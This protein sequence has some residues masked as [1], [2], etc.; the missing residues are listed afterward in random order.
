MEHG[1]TQRGRGDSRRS[2][3]ADAIDPNAEFERSRTPS[4]EGSATAAPPA[5]SQPPSTA[6][7]SPT[8]RRG[9][10]QARLARTLLP[11]G[12]TPDASPAIVPPDMLKVAGT[13]SAAETSTPKQLAL[14]PSVEGDTVQKP[15]LVS[16]SKST[17]SSSG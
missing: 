17:D 8:E 16:T 12:E 2:S 10:W 14:P 9:G 15:P 7:P 11:P 3:H 13:P 1:A 6:S 5:S 4:P